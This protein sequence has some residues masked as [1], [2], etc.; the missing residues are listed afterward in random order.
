MARTETGEVATPVKNNKPEIEIST[1]AGWLQQHHGS[2]V[3]NLQPLSGGFWSAAF[4]YE[5]AGEEYVVRFNQS[6]GGFAIDQAAHV[7]SETGLPVPEV[8]E[9]GEALDLSYA[10]SRRHHGRF[11]ETVAPEAAPRL[12]HALAEMFTQLRSVPSNDK[13][14]WYDQ[15]SEGSWHDYLL[16][17]IDS[18]ADGPQTDLKQALKSRPHLQDIY[19]VACRRIHE[20]L[21]LC[22]ERRDLVH[23]DL[24][25]Q[26]VLI[27][28]QADKVQAVFSWKCSA[29]GDFAYDIAWCTHWAPWHPGIAALDVLD[30]ARTASDLNRPA[31]D[32]LAERHHCYELQIAASHVGWYLWTRDEENLALLTEGL[33]RRLDRGP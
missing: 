7:F 4:A 11:L 22:P 31:G 1:V 2:A 8:F 9:I 5:R 30:L 10:I 23:G 17:S 33:R 3:A 27:S 32:H 19:Q 15:T 25:H 24:L 26:N 28:E 20:L 18:E 14:K 16:R 13:V 21:P 12:A 29:F 6:P